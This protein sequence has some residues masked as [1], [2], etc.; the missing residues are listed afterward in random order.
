M[1]RF[2]AGLILLIAAYI[3]QQES[4]PVTTTI[5]S[6]EGDWSS[7]PAPRQEAVLQDVLASLSVSPA[8]A[9]P[10]TGSEA[11]AQNVEYQYYE[12]SAYSCQEAI[13]QAAEVGPVDANGV[14]W[15]AL[16]TWGI[17]WTARASGD[18]RLSAVQVNWQAVVTLP[19]W[20]PSADV[21][22]EETDLWNSSVDQLTEHEKGH[23]EIVSSSI[24]GI[25]DALN[26]ATKTTAQQTFDAAFQQVEQRQEQYE[27][28]TNHGLQE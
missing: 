24:P 15:T 13:D 25:V 3:I 28:T 12:V 4:G 27:A 11:A 17:S 5:G 23:V 7:A 9:S 10:E 22:V 20:A 26:S 2:V 1:K 19:R 6:R 16:T 18:G 21:P 8:F 14:R